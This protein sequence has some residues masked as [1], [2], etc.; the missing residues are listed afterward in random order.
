MTSR[1]W[2]KLYCDQWLSGSLREGTPELRGIWA[3]LLA[4]AG[5]GKYGDTGRISLQN[6]V[7]L[8]DSQFGKLLKITKYQWQKAKKRLILT[9]RIAVNS[10]N[11]VTIINWKKYQSEYERQKPYRHRVLDVLRAQRG[12]PC[13]Y[14]NRVNRCYLINEVTDWLKQHSSSR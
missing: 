4:L 8:S 1:T 5:S 13:V 2:V 6:D 12:F 7:G 11:V 14:L 10:A 3:D 9:E